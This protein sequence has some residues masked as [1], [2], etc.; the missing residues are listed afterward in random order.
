MPG[1]TEKLRLDK[2]LWA[3]RIF[4]TRS[5]AA[6]ACDKNKVKMNGNALKAAKTVNIGDQ[7]EIKTEA[8]KWVIKVTGLLF[9][10]VAFSEAVNYYID[11]TPKEEI[12][13]TSDR[14]ASFNTGKRM[15]KTGRPTKKQ[16][17]DLEDFMAV[18][19]TH[20]PVL[21]T[22]LVKVSHLPG[23]RRKMLSKKR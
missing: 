23:V 13:E 20:L 12:N 4:K 1:S 3:I 11:I 17:R 9:D 19:Y 2:Y 8:K 16:Q 15:S 10:R 7:Y 22:T 6:E 21:F 18:S 5:Q 14:S